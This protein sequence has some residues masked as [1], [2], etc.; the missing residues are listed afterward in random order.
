MRFNTLVQTRHKTVNRA[1]GEAFVQE[2]KLALASLILTSFI[3]DQF[4]RSASG[5][6]QELVHRI[7]AL[8]DKQFAAKAAVFARNEYGMRSISHVVAGEIAARVKGQPWTRAFFDRVVR[9]PDDVTEILSYYLATH[10][11]PVPNALKKGLGQALTR[12]DSYQVSKYRG[13]RTALSLVDAVNLVHPKHTD[14]LGALVRGTLQPA[15]TW[16]V[17]LTQAGQAADKADAKREAWTELI[18]AR[19]LGYFALL[20]NLRNILEQ[21]PEVLEEALSMLVDERLIR[22]TLVLPFRFATA[23]EELGKTAHPRTTEVLQALNRALDVSLANVPRFAGRTLVVLDG[24]GSMRGRP[25]QIGS[26]FAAVM[27]K[28]NVAD[29]V[30]FSNDAKYVGVNPEDTTLTIAEVIRGKAPFGGTN[31]HA[32]IDLVAQHGRA[33]DRLIFLSDMQGWIGYDVPTATLAAYEQRVGVR[34]HVYSFD[35][36]GYGSTQFPRDRIY[37]LT[38]FSEKTF[39]V[40]QVLEQDRNALVRQIEAVEL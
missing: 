30:V 6:V 39:E 21:A 18:R 11:K 32:P 31:F 28:A 3:Q 36:Q 4:Y 7:E 19:K 17:K 13:E 14:A 35:L 40:M 9:R 34:P 1:G 5:Q 23:I 33:Y 16:E 24:S 10:G 25:L 8:P 15:A 2:P 29:L 12:F 20:R 37:C 26:L 38:G 27:V 22:K